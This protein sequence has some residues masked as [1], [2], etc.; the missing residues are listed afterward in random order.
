MVGVVVAELVVR[1]NKRGKK[2]YHILAAL[3]TT[4]RQGGRPALIRISLYKHNRDPPFSTNVRIMHSFNVKCK[5]TQTRT[6]K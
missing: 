4:D 1:V 6:T 3:E 2:R 5:G